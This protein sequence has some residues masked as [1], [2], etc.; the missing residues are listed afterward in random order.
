MDLVE[1]AC[2]INQKQL[3]NNGSFPLFHNTSTVELS[4]TYHSAPRMAVTLVDLKVILPIQTMESV[5]FLQRQWSLIE[6]SASKPFMF[7]GSF[8]GQLG[9]LATRPN[10]MF[11]EVVFLSSST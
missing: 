4:S 2:D 3:A 6:D 8:F 11:F 7:M 9:L 1:F 10:L 5:Y